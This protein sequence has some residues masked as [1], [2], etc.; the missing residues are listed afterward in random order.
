MG[1][2]NNFYKFII[3]YNYLQLFFIKLINNTKMYLKFL[4]IIIIK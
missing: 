2:L 1:L 4:K 3:L